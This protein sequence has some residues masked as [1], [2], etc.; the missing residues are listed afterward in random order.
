MSKIIAYRCSCGAE[1]DADSIHGTIVE[2][3]YC[4]NH[5]VLPQN[6]SLLRPTFYKITRFEPK[7]N[8][9]TELLLDYLCRK[10][11]YKLFNRLKVKGIKFYYVPTRLVG[12]GNYAY[13]VP[14][15][16]SH[17]SVFAN[18]FHNKRLY[19]NEYAVSING[20]LEDNIK[21]EDYKPVYNNNFKV[22]ILPVDVSVEKVDALHGVN[23]Q[24]M[25]IVKYLPFFV[26]ETNLC[27]IECIGV[28][29]SFAVVN[30]KEV[31]KAIK[32][33]FE[34][35]RLAELRDY[36]KD[37]A[38]TFVS[39]AIIGLVIYLVYSFFTMGI[40]SIGHLLQVILGIIVIAFLCVWTVIWVGLYVI[41]CY[42]VI[43]PVYHFLHCVFYREKTERVPNADKGR[44]IINSLQPQYM[45]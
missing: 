3:R 11:H 26:L 37:N 41:A 20:S 28:D 42:L 25:L 35:N 34:S 5:F 10:G 21:Y 6:D 16:E 30:E 14:L 36:L 23:A 12:T 44:K 24:S 43:A 2:C 39:L 40:S 8:R 4:H 15:N 33:N 1:I 32:D 9:Y 27:N 17:N 22:E 29:E 38:K 45:R 13:Y 19:A 7:I 31:L 18:L